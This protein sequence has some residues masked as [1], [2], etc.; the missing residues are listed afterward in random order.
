[1]NATDELNPPAPVSNGALL[2]ER[3]EARG[4][5]VE[6]ASHAL[7]LTPRQ[8]AAL[9]ADELEALPGPTFARGFLRNYARY[10]QLDP[11]P[12]L[13]ALEGMPRT[14][15]VDLEPISNASGAMP[16]AAA[17]A[18]PRSLIGLAVVA[19]LALGVTVYFDR[20][21]SPPRVAP[22]AAVAP[23]PVVAPQPESQVMAANAAATP[24]P[25]DAAAP[26][27]AAPP[28]GEVSAAAASAPA[29]A[30][31]VAPVV[32]AAPKRIALRFEA[33]SWVEIR[34]AEGKVLMSKI[35]QPGTSDVVEGGGPLPFALVI[36]NAQ[37]V[38][39]E[40]DGK[41]LDL[42]PHTSVSVARLKVE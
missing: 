5:S 17:R 6:D 24:Q 25:A 15:Q 19:V 22:A 2:R 11:E 39:V 1:M 32:A 3:R 29:A 4:L 13:A 14:P 28:A 41:P 36:G 31:P 18:V 23:P 16:A 34:D 10:L 30:A 9:E 33:Q 12:M 37:G 26:A 27:L 38:R 8:I 40:V 21:A 42:A 7:K 20:F 35:G